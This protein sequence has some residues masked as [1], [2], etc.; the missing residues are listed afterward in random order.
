MTT[1]A[2][3]TPRVSTDVSPGQLFAQAFA[4]DPTSADV[5][6]DYTI[7]DAFRPTK[8]RPRVT[9]R[10]LFRKR[11]VDMDPVRFWCETRPDAD[12]AETVHESDLRR[13]AAFR[14]GMA[15]AQVHPIRAWVQ[16]PEEL[17]RDLDALA[18]FVDYR[19]LV[20]LA[21]AENQ[22][23]TLGEH[24]LLRHPE[25]ARLPYDGDYLTGLLDACNEIEQTGATPHAMI[26]NPRDY[27]THLLG[28]G[29]LLTDFE[30]NGMQISR[31]RMVAP[32]TAVVGDFAMAA[33]LLDAGQSAIRVTEPPAG[34][35]ATDGLAV[36]AE[37]HE[38]LAVHL[39]THI[40]HVVPAQG[41]PA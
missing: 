38:G 16:V 30:R 13:E 15:E 5:R 20:R 34:I 11:P 40:H 32:G 10:N 19:L 3:P 27:Y 37:I 22:A 12:E 21:T 2:I 6:F 26:V 33:R 24:G 8:E 1:A 31:T 36:C 39:P 23:L 41:G 28:H 9:V 7:T 17:T 18:V 4:A 35:F 25:I 14:F 29:S